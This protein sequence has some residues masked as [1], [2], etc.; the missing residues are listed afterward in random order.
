MLSYTWA[1]SFVD[2]GHRCE[3]SQ[4]FSQVFEVS[5]LAINSFGL[6]TVGRKGGR[7]TARLCC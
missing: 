1:G 5:K 4:H 7:L 6:W 3:E 2:R